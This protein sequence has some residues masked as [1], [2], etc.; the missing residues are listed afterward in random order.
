M[1]VQQNKATV[2]R[3]VRAYND[4]DLDTLRNIFSHNAQLQG[5]V[6]FGSLEFTLSVWSDLHEGLRSYLTI[7]AMCAEGN[8]VTTR[9][10]E[11]GCFERP[12]KLF[13]DAKPTG[14]PY[15]LIVME[16]FTFDETGRITQ[17]WCVRDIASQMRQIGLLSH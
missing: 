7:E 9:C 1:S 12:C 6:G 4:N 11:V 10:Q 16:W 13:P 15:M 2:E 14:R 8:T 3:Y 17:R 5:V